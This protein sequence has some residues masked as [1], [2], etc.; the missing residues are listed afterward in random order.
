MDF[1]TRGSHA[2]TAGGSGDRIFA[3]RFADE[4]GQPRQAAVRILERL[5]F[6]AR[7]VDVQKYLSLASTPQAQLEA[8][9]DWQ[10]AWQSID[11]SDLEQRITAAGYQTLNLSASQLWA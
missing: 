3:D 4:S 9:L 7:P 2:E 8:W 1:T 5:S 10:L 11:D 6:G